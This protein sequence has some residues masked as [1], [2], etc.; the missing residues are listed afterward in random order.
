[1]SVHEAATVW[2][3]R[4]LDENRLAGLGL[5]RRHLP[6]SVLPPYA[7]VTRR[8]DVDAVLADDATFA[9]P[10]LPR[11]TGPFLLGLAGD[12]HRHASEEL[13][14]VVR[15]D[16]L[17]R[18]QEVARER[19][20][21]RVDRVPR[22]GALDVGTELVHPVLSELVEDYLGVGAPSW[23]VQL[24]WARDLFSDI[25]L[26][27]S[28]LPSV[29]LRAERS[30]TEFCRWVEA[31]IDERPHGAAARA[32]GQDDVLG[33]LLARQVEAPATAFDDREVRDNLIGLAVGWLW[34][35]AK[36]ALTVVDELLER[37][38]QLADAR[39][40]ARDD[41]LP[42]LQR[43]A[44]E[45]LRFRPVQPFLLRTCTRDAVLARGTPRERRVGVGT[46]V[47]VGTHSAM[48][49]EEVVPDPQAFDAARADSAYLVF[50]AGLH[51]CFGEAVVRAQLP[52]LL[53]PLLAVEGLRRAEGRS[54]R[55]RWT[56]PSPNGLRVL[57]GG[58]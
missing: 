21:R 3:Q 43:L 9:P 28:G 18:L 25:F 48:W 51:R 36:A 4:R 29:R 56:G 35:G 15:A 40:A 50:G 33:R 54:G 22:P 53:A 14:A 46:I 44:W 41:D 19:A 8:E 10:Y 52:A 34:H 26:N 20:R 7:V 58:G 12:D 45:A 49:D 39:A 27:P 31:R 6:V 38:A 23:T 30:G 1:V 16:D 24:Q 13:R 17:P 11:L 47:V 42:A 5:L 55:L 2:V 57:L 32:Q 37:P